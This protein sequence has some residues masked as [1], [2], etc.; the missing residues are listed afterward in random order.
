[1]CSYHYRLKINVNSKGSANALFFQ[2]DPSLSDLTHQDIFML[3]LRKNDRIKLTN[4]CSCLID[5]TRQIVQTHWPKGLTA[6]DAKRGG[7]EFKL[8]GHPWNPQKEESVE[9]R[10]I[11]GTI[12]Q[13]YRDA[14]PY[15]RRI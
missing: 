15:A 8:N 13:I 14:W 3:T 1:M 10:I 5:D 7:Y 11:T 2:Y 4:A 12:L 9:A 6:E